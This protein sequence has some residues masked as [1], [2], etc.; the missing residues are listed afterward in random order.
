MT[1]KKSEARKRD[2]KLYEVD[3]TEV[4]K[5]NKRIKIH[6]VGTIARNLTSGDF[7]MAARDRRYAPNFKCDYPN[8]ICL[9]YRQISTK[10]KK[11]FPS[12]SILV[13]R[14]LHLNSTKRKL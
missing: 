7:L 5:V 3:I 6:F 14:E 2:K 13:E 1:V 10:F 8:R 12:F 9:Q 4:D 11:N